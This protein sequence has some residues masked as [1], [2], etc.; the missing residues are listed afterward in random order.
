[1]LG[2]Q[3]PL[4]RTKL[5]PPRLPRQTLARDNLL[6]RLAQAYELPL[7][8]VQAGAGY[9]KS[10][11]LAAFAA[12]QTATVWYHLEAEDA[13]PLR[14]LQHLLYGL[15]QVDFGLVE[16]AQ[17]D[18]GHASGVVPQTAQER[19][20]L[21]RLGQGHDLVPAAETHPRTV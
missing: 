6:S 21:R 17:T 10:T 9:G 16:V 5:I 15:G 1:M 2:H 18:R 3:Q 7:T 8:I 12:Q 13:D 19:V 14:F 4:I 20:L 11:A